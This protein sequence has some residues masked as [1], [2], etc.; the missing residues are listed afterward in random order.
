MR[1]VQHIDEVKLAVDIDTLQR[2]GLGVVRQEDGGLRVN[3]RYLFWSSTKFW[4]TDDEG[5]RGYGVGN[6]IVAAVQEEQ[7]RARSGA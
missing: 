6:L 1:T 7:R 3:G 4:R 5:E 2:A